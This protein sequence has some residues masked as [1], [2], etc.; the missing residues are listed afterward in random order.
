MSYNLEKGS[1][2][3][4]GSELQGKFC[5]LCGEK[6]I[7]PGKDFALKKFTEQVIDGFTHFDSKIVNSFKKLFFAPGQLT[8]HYIEGIRVEYMKPVQLFIVASIIFYFF[9]PASASFYT[10]FEE[11]HSG[12]ERKGF[13]LQNPT[14]Y[15]INR[16]LVL[17]ARK[18]M[19]DTANKDALR[20]QANAIY[21]RAIGKAATMSKTLLFLILPLLAFLGY[22]LYFKK[23]RFYV[24]HVIFATHTFSFFLLLDVVF[25]VFYFN[26]LG[27]R[28]VEN[29]THMLP[30]FLI[31]QL[32]IIL[33]LRKLYK[34]SWVVTITK[35]ISY[36]AA[37]LI[38]LYFYRIFITIWAVQAA[39]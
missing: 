25:L 4:C 12:F 10:S 35:G 9:M 32:Y 14:K 17:K 18:K 2:K 16:V 33:A 36:N 6:T 34:Q 21:E 22:L 27:L 29:H 5:S 24:P 15:D 23:Q 20:Q 30:F 19:P 39:G 8:Q 13:S 37:L 28:V 3:S 31:I 38:L 7:D 11:L 1:C 26:I